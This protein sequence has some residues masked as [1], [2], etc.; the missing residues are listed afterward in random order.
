MTTVAEGV[1]TEK[2]LEM[3]LAAGCYEGQGYLFSP[4]VPREKVLELVAE[5]AHALVKVA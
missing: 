4:P 5:Q 3:L 2:D 1:E